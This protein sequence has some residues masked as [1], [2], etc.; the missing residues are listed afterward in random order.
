[1]GTGATKTDSPV[2]YFKMQGQDD[3]V[4]LSKDDFMIVLMTPYQRD[5]ISNYTDDKVLVDSTHETT[6][7]DFLLTPLE[8]ADEYG[9]G[10]PVAYCL[11][12]RVDTIAM[13]VF[14]SIRQKKK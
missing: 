1:M 12:N 13:K 2:H 5:V 8:S 6:N 3:E 10:C 9:V 14:F 4:L 11:S 7:H